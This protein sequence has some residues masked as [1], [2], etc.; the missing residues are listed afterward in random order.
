MRLWR[1]S[2]AKPHDDTSKPVVTN[3]DPKPHEETPK[4]RLVLQRGV[5]FPK[6]PVLGVDQGIIDEV[7]LIT[8]ESTCDGL[9]EN[10]QLVDVVF[11]PKPF[12]PQKHD[13]DQ[14]ILLID[15]GLAKQAISAYQ[16]RVIDLMSFD[17]NLNLIAYRPV[18]E[19][20]KD[21][22]LI[23]KRISNSTQSLSAINFSRISAD[24]AA[25]FLPLI[26][27]K[28]APFSL[29][30]GHGAHIASFLFE[31]N[32][33]AQLLLV[34]DKHWMTTSSCDAL[35]S[36]DENVVQ[37]ELNKLKSKQD[38]ALTGLQTAIQE[39][40]IGMINAS[41]G[42]SRQILNETVAAKCG[43]IFNQSV[44]SALLNLEHRYIDKLSMMSYTT[45]LNEV[46]HPLLVQ[47]AVSSASRALS[48][49]DAAFPIDCDSDI[50]PRLRV[51]NPLASMKNLGVEAVPLEGIIDNAKL[52][53][54]DYNIWN[55]SDVYISTGGY[56]DDGIK[57]R[58]RTFPLTLY[59]VL[60]AG[61]IYSVFHSSSFSTPI[62]VST[63]NYIQGQSSRR[64]TAQEL[65][66]EFVGF[67][68]KVLDPLQH[69]LFNVYKH[70]V[71]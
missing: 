47:A 2:S 4:D 69:D 28:D 11:E 3:P 27:E 12:N 30:D 8:A 45:E 38:N 18:I 63:L 35:D 70:S 68:K 40:E 66:E 67:E 24:F 19:M 42:V 65:I 29:G 26:N 60:T 71:N 46:R 54:Q 43:K 58:K 61:P 62:A 33:K 7:A 34:E 25:K 51:A 64:L 53:T 17:E 37:S 56:K 6:Y 41:F 5:I 39:H 55:C 23:F 50:S 32:P 14:R 22:E 21:A 36:K 57:H 15:F 16:D 9:K 44:M 13:R 1:D 20:P 59:G 10:C 49:D 31:Y 48:E 52:S